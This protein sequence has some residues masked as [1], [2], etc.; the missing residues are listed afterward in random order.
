[1]DSTSLTR[2]QLLKCA[3]PAIFALAGLARPV[4]GGQN[5]PASASSPAVRAVTRGP[6]FHWFS[7]Y[8]KLQFDPSCRYALATEV[9]F[10]HR[11]PTP[12]DAITVGM[13]DLENNDRWTELG[14]SSAWCWQQGC[15]LQ[16]RPGSDSEILYND[17]E[18][19]RFVSHIL[20][21]KTKTERTISHPFYTISPDGRTAVA[22][23]FARVDAM[24]PGYGY[25]GLPDSHADQL[26]PK[27]SGIFSIDLETGRRELIISLDDIARFGK[28]PGQPRNPKHY[29]NHLLFNPDGSRFIFLHRWRATDNSPYRT[30]GGFGTRMLTASPDG[31]NIRIV[32]PHGKTSHFIWRDPAHILAWAW[33]PSHGNAFYLY[34]DGTDK[35]EVVGRAVMTGNG[36]CSYLPG[37]E[38]ILNDTYPDRNRNQNLYLYNVA[39]GQRVPLG[40]FRLPPEYKGEWRCDTHPR[41]SPD[42]RNVCIDS[43]HAGNGRQMYL[44]DISRITRPS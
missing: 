37:N 14:R 11:S 44:I 12:D 15:M 43:P 41:F 30:V 22:P 26:A 7:Y 42:G 27:D 4:A 16:W 3:P 40:S 8:D 33:H 32:D 20:D 17:R 2:R 38:W 39:T 34:E 10:E 13:I 25:K 35:V 28:I 1:M 24:R 31:G 19:G 29:F 5:P 18:S 21:V 9:D 36:H 6:K 23:D